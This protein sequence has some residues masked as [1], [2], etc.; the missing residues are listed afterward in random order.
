MPRQVLSALGLAWR[1]VSD[2]STA[3]WLFPS[4][5]G[6]LASGFLS[7]IAAIIGELQHVPIYFWIPLSLATM[8]AALCLFNL[9]RY[10]LRNLFPRN[11]LI[12]VHISSVY[13]GGN[14]R[15]CTFEPMIS[16]VISLFCTEKP[17]IVYNMLIRLKSIRGC[18]EFWWQATREYSYFSAGIE[19]TNIRSSGFAVPREWTKMW[20]YFRIREK[21]ASG[22]FLFQDG[23]YLLEL[24]ILDKD[25]NEY[26]TEKIELSL[27]EEDCSHIVA[28]EGVYFD[29]MQDPRK[30]IVY[31]SSHVHNGA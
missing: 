5:W 9:F 30:V 13:L 28:Q 20:P 22:K 14:D 29:I 31:H 4:A 24:V 25:H 26:A 6:F 11:K 2:A 18:Q 1:R 8:I 10:V 21:D 12:N 17:F 3:S 15:S 16:L 23:I 7:I 27:N 19:P